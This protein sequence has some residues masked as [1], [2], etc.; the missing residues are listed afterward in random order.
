MNFIKGILLT[1]L[2]CQWSTFAQVRENHLDIEITV[3]DE[4]GVY[5]WSKE[6]K[7]YELD[8]LTTGKITLTFKK[9]TGIFRDIERAIPKEESSA[10]IMT[11][12]ASIRLLM[13]APTGNLQLVTTF[14][15]GPSSKRT[16][17]SD[18]VLIK[19]TYADYLD[20][21]TIEFTLT[22]EGQ[23]SLYENFVREGID[24][25]TQSSANGN[26]DIERQMNLS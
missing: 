3:S 10:S 22:S 11:E 15:Y 12:R 16:F 24:T 6:S 8:Q 26:K 1:A 5:Q 21:E 2:L 14:H 4:R 19:G 25:L 13:D 9:A 20:G 18:I 7:T 17:L 23:I